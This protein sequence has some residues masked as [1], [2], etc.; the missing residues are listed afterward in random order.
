MG[1]PVSGKMEAQVSKLDDGR[2]QAADVLTNARSYG[3]AARDEDVDGGLV[4]DVVGRVGLDAA[5]DVHPTHD[6]PKDDV[7]RVAPGRGDGRDEELRE[8][9]RVRSAGRTHGGVAAKAGMNGVGR[10]VRG[11]RERQEKGNGEEVR[12]GRE[13]KKREGKRE[14]RDTTKGRTCDEF[15]CG[16]RFAMERRPGR[17]CGMRKFSSGGAQRRRRRMSGR[18]AERK[19]K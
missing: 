14:G 9:V 7:A 17:S 10:E 18:C 12:G 15:V 4:E 16:P 19:R 2:R 11:D 3:P 13:R 6:L 5:D 8:G 1:L